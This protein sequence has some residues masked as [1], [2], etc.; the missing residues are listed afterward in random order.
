[1]IDQYK[2]E[3]TISK[4][5]GMNGTHKYE[6]KREKIPFSLAKKRENKSGGEQRRCEIEEGR[7]YAKPGQTA[8]TNSP[9][10]IIRFHHTS[11]FRGLLQIRIPNNI[12]NADAAQCQLL[13]RRSESPALR[14]L[15]LVVC[16]PEEIGEGPS[17]ATAG[18]FRPCRCAREPVDASRRLAAHADGSGGGKGRRRRPCRRWNR[19][20]RLWGAATAPPPLS[21]VDVAVVPWP[22]RLLENY[23][24]APPGLPGMMWGPRSSH[25]ARAAKWS[26]LPLT[27]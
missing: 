13:L 6:K 27:A 12:A 18:A 1:M 17:S 8:R 22:P 21:S 7:R 16:F 2:L 26:P 15:L 23:T 19:R 25:T 10:W 20:C 3:C 11:E 4:A 5:T 24:N 9:F 14:R